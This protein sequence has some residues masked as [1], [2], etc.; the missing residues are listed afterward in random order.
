[1]YH[2]SKFQ[3]HKLSKLLD[4]FDSNLSEVSNM[5]A[6]GYRRIWDSGNIVYTL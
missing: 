1:L 5:Y 6:N 3:K 4:N 2:R